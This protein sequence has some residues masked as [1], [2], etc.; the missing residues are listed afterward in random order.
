VKNN[1]TAALRE[2]LQNF[3]NLFQHQSMSLLESVFK[4]LIKEN[5]KI[6]SEIEKKEGGEKI[7]LLLTDDTSLEN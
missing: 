1:N 6:L 4:Y 2:N 3:R 7:S 5:N